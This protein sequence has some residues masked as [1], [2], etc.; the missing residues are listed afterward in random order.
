MIHYWIWPLRVP[1]YYCVNLLKPK[2]NKIEVRYQGPEIVEVTE[3]VEIK[4]LRI[5]KSN[6]KMYF[7]FWYVLIG[8]QMPFLV[9]LYWCIITAFE[10]VILL[11]KILSVK[12]LSWMLHKEEIMTKHTNIYMCVYIY[13]CMLESN[14]IW[15]F[16]TLTVFLTEICYKETRK[17]NNILMINTMQDF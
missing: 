4:P 13:L 9:L 10:T 2:K 12:R 16:W 5:P 7:R 17:L 15:R 14:D 1:K 6:W 11:W 3:N 8:C